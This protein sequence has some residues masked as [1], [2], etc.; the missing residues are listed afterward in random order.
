MTKQKEMAVGIG[1][2]ALGAE[3]LY[4]TVGGID[5]IKNAATE[6]Q[7]YDDTILSAA[8]HSYAAAN[9]AARTS[10]TNSLRLETARQ[11]FDHAMKQSTE[12]HQAASSA[13]T[14]DG[15]FIGAIGQQLHA[16]EN[17]VQHNL[18]GAFLV[19]LFAGISG[20]AIWNHQKQSEKGKGR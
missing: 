16:G 14:F 9:D 5:A 12:L 4:D 8:R 7:R 1:A 2:A 20:L 11:A 19:A 17:V 15:G 3:V 13:E 18:L 6:A 10:G